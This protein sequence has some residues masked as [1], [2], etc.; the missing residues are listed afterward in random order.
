MNGARIAY[1]GTQMLR[2]IS[3]AIALLILSLAL[4]TSALADDDD[5]DDN[6]IPI[7]TC[8][9]VITE[10]GN[11]RVVNDLLE[12]SEPI[13]FGLFRIG[14][15]VYANDVTLD[16][17]RH[18][19]RCADIQPG[20]NTRSFGIY[21]EGG[22]FPGT[23]EEYGNRVRI[24]N[25]VIENC[26][27]GV[28]TGGSTGSTIE[29]LT[30]SDG[31]FGIAVGTG[32]DYRIRGNHISEMTSFGIYLSTNFGPTNGLRV[33][34]NLIHDAGISGIFATGISDTKIRCN[35]TDRNG[36]GGII[37]AGLS[38]GL[39][40]RNNVANDNFLTGIFIAGTSFGDFPL[41]PVP[42]GN[43]VRGNT[44]L[45]N[46]HDLAEASLDFSDPFLSTVLVL[47]DAQ[48]LNTWAGNTY[49]SEV[50]PLDC[51]APSRPIDDDDDD[52]CA[53]DYGDEDDDDEDD[54]DD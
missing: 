52:G 32:F 11:Y 43:T 53:P 54:D 30:I 12:C 49:I 22:T 15:S 29:K 1:R 13:Q 40:I 41:D 44:A 10:P 24:R 50:A 25:G 36:I 51:I 34:K 42:S 46:V 37:A 5:D 23:G 9:A 4:P 48:C 17:G 26:Q 2:I 14:I 39:D 19:I 7:T 28:A 47:P 31:E 21:L 27:E 16:L 18:T 33:T 45:G 8:G 6:Y 3:A 20:D 38:T 35:R